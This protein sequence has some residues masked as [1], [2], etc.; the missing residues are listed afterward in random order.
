MVRDSNERSKRKG[1]AQKE[2][3]KS[4]MQPQSIVVDA[5]VKNTLE[6]SRR[7]FDHAN[8]EHNILCFDAQ[9]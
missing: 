4:Q 9:K 2:M 1:G 6:L 5:F 7:G 3:R 8:A